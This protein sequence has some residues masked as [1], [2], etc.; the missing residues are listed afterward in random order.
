MIAIQVLSDLHLEAPRA[1][2]IFETTPRAPYLALL[3]SIDNMARD[4]EEH[5]GGATPRT[6]CTGWAYS[7]SGFAMELLRGGP[8]GFGDG[9]SG[10]G[11]NATKVEVKVWAFGHTYFNC[12]FVDE[13]GRRA[14]SNQRGCYFAQVS[15][16][17]AEKVVEV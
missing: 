17:D 6:R 5:T 4:L 2:D 7:L 14:Y 10:G 3:G 12:D 9:V 13:A 1:C 11:G 16:F 15:G 8:N